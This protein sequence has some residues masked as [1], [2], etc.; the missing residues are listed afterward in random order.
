MMYPTVKSSH[1]TINSYQLL[2]VLPCNMRCCSPE[3]GMLPEA[4]AEGNIPTKG[5]QHAC[6]MAEHL[7]I[8]L[9]YH[10]HMDNMYTCNITAYTCIHVIHHST[11]KG[12]LSLG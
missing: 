11:C 6:Y 8:D 9:L 2:N 7:T 5:E 12:G 3:V 10:Y 4:S 1:D